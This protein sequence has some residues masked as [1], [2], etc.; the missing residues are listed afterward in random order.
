MFRARIRPFSADSEWRER[1]TFRFEG[2]PDAEPYRVVDSRGRA[3]RTDRNGIV[4][5]MIRL[6]A[7]KADFLLEAGGQENDWV[8]WEAVSRG[9]QGSGRALLVPPEGTSVVSDIDDTL[10]I[11]EIPA[12]WGTALRNT[13]FEEFRE[14]P[15]MPDLLS[16]WETEEDPCST[17][18]QEPPGNSTAHFPRS[19]SMRIPGIPKARCTSGRSGRT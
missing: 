16:E 7:G 17:T 3:L 11:T 5:G 4:E 13:F 10:R 19:S 8:E 12:G 2:D 18:F 1:V 15:G 9:H 14:A 6:P